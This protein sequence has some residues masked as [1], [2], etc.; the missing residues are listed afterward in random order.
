MTD[1]FISYARPVE[2]DAHRIAEAFTGLGYEVWRDDSLSPNEMFAEVIEERLRAAKAVLVVWSAAGA[3]SQWVRAEADVAREAGTLVQLSLDGTRPPLPF[4]QIHCVDLSGW[5]GDED[6]RQWRKIVQT[7][8]GLVGTTRKP[9][10]SRPTAPARHP[11][12]DLLAV[13]PFDNI[14]GDSEI[15]FFS[16]G[17]SEEILQT[18]ASIPALKVIGRSSSF[19]FRGAA[20]ATANVASRLRATHILDGSVR[21][22]G[23]RVRITATLVECA[24]QTSIWSGRFDRDLS[25]V[26]AL[27]DEIAAAVAAALKLVFSADATPR[28]VDPAAYELYLRARRLV[29]VRVT[30]E[31]GLDLLGAVVR[32]AP[33][34]AAAWSSLAIARAVDA[35]RIG[36]PVEFAGRR[37]GVVDAAERALALDPG[38]G[39]AFA[40]LSL[41][42]PHASYARRETLLDKALAAGASDGETLRQASYFHYG[43]GRVRKSFDLV[44][45]AHRLDPL[46]QS[47]VLSHA[48]RLGDTGGLDGYYDALGDAR[49]QWPDFIWLFSSP[50]L[51]AAMRRDWPRVES[52]IVEAKARGIELPPHITGAVGLLRAPVEDVRDLVLSTAERQLETTGTVQLGWICLTYSIGLH[53]EAFDLLERASFEHLFVSEGGNADDRFLPGVIFGC[54]SGE[55]RTDPRFVDLCAKLG[56]CD[57]WAETGRW[58]DCVEETAAFYDF[59][60]RATALSRTA[61]HSRGIPP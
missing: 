1:I 23:D 7:V 9:A 50:I 57:Y 53:D 18:V 43:V 14:S 13:L 56:L 24:G 46:N 54:T 12:E 4:N 42:E 15:G 2:A 10:V 37:G 22:N 35:R 39:L 34:F 44:E 25:D 45:Q 52:L 41:L 11:P 31:E 49:R 30:A 59:K 38:S 33:D 47:I 36:D 32:L 40:A 3:K 17:I 55:L 58:P 48:E 28:K 8:A 61:S 21:R 5:A 26:F 60:A 27:Q 6:N 29:G 16:D 51:T 19:Q 20:K